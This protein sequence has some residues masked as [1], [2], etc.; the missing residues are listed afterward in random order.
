MGIVACSSN[1]LDERDNELGNKETYVN[2]SI[3]LPSGQKS[4]ALPDDYNTD[5]TYEGNDYVKT[6]DIYIINTTGE[7]EEAKRFYS[8]GLSSSNGVYSPSQPFRTTSGYKQIYV[9]LNSPAELATTLIKEN[10]LISIEGLAAIENIDGTDYDVI[11]MT[12]KTSSDVYIEP[13]VPAQD[14]TTGANRFDIEVTRSASRVIVTLDQDAEKELTDDNGNLIG[15]VSN[16]TWSVAQ[17]TNKIYWFEQADYLT[18]GSEFVPVFGDK[19]TLYADAFTYYNYSDLSSNEVIPL[20]PDAADG[21]KSLKGKFLFENTHKTGDIKTTD[22]RKG[23]TAYVLVRAHFTPVPEAIAD[24]GKLTNGTFYVGQAD[25]KI[26]SSKSAAQKDIK[27]QAVVTYREGKMLNY[28]WLNPDDIKTPLNS[29]VLRNHIYHI[30]ITG[31]KRLAYSWNPLYPE[32]PNTVN[33]QNP[34]PKPSPEE[35]VSPI[36]PLDPLTPE[37][38]YMTVDVKVLDWATH[39]YDIEF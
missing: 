7:V 12:G 4:R 29:P 16:I 9:V 37:Q 22:Y 11:T 24:G 2:L 8:S 3:K 32:D 21:Y 26:Y 5:G 38:T 14:V 17:G 31:F 1:D 10:D 19:E 25:G 20:K 33:P 23:N 39:S 6:L 36:D 30:N 15:T 13:D 35:P 34:D 27:N 18:F 28:A